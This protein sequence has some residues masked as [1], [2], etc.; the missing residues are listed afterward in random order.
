VTKARRIRKRVRNRTLR[1]ASKRTRRRRISN[2][3]GALERKPATAGADPG[4]TLCD[5]RCSGLAHGRSCF[6]QTKSDCGWHP[7]PNDFHVRY[8]WHEGSVPPPYHSRRGERKPSIKRSPAWCR[9]GFGPNWMRSGRRIRTN[10]SGGK[11]RGT[12]QT[13]VGRSQLSA[14]C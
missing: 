14:P 8:E 13:D 6:C 12:E 11:N 5:W 10:N 1:R 3:K 4:Q 7:A 2:R 9:Q